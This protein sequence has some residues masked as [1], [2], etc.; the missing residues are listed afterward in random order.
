LEFSDVFHVLNVLASNLLRAEEL[1][2]K[3]RG[4]EEKMNK[5]LVFLT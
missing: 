1:E 5:V 4:T 2:N 3:Q